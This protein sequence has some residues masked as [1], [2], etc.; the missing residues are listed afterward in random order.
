MT[1]YTTLDQ[2]AFFHALW[3]QNELYSKRMLL[4]I[5]L[6]LGMIVFAVT[7]PIHLL[8]GTADWVIR[9]CLCA[10]VLALH[11]VFSERAR[12]KMLGR[13]A[14][15]IVE[16]NGGDLR[17]E[18]R[19]GEESFFAIGPNGEEEIPYSRIAALCET[20][21]V[22]LLVLGRFFVHAIRKADLA[23]ERRRELASLLMDRTGQPWRAYKV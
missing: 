8:G 14:A 4:W 5:R 9:A 23:A 22:F 20:D 10:L 11:A 15:D 21:G 13:T 18:Y 7:I 6:I 3:A 19:F 16:A 17:M 2:P 1:V 12:R